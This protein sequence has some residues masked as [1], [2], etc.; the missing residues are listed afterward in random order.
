MLRSQPAAPGAEAEKHV[1][2]ATPTAKLADEF[3]AAVSGSCGPSRFNRASLGDQ[4]T[5]TAEHPAAP[6][7]A[8]SETSR[9]QMAA[10]EKIWADGEIAGKSASR[11]GSPPKPSVGGNHRRASMNCR[12]AL[13]IGDVVNLITT[14]A[15]QPICWP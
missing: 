6:G 1:P 3:E 8:A 5:R 14:I 13:R 4:L 9:C 7:S 12:A 15:E 11:T 2:N 10:T